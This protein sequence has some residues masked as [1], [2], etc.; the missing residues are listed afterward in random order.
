MKYIILDG[1]EG[2][3]KS[4]QIA[5]LKAHLAGLGVDGV[6][7]T[8]EPGGTGVGRAIRNILLSEWE[9]PPCPEAEISLFGA[10][11]VQH[12][13][14][15]VAPTLRAGWHVIQDRGPLATIAYQGY[16]R[17]RK[18]LIRDIEEMNRRAL[19]GC[20]PDLYVIFDCPAEVGLA[21]KKQQNEIT[22]FEREDVA[23]HERVRQGFLECK[24]QYRN[25]MIDASAGADDVWDKFR[26]KME[27]ELGIA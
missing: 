2:C 5:R 6:V 15:V 19:A 13:K 16:G 12:T 17:E 1:V 25:I 14:T 7:Y 4:T 8:R 26:A 21:R 20:L 23:F 22:R 9:E 11:R 3:G 27:R 10:D 18:Y 24:D